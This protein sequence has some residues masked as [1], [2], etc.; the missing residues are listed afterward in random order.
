MSSIRRD[1]AHRLTLDDGHRLPVRSRIRLGGHRSRSSSRPRMRRRTCRSWSRRSSEAFRPLVGRVDRSASARRV[2]GRGRRRRLDRP[3]GPGPPPTGRDLSRAEA[4]LPGDERRPVGGDGRGVPGGAG[5]LGR[6]ARRG[7]SESS[8]RPGGALGRPAGLR[9]G[10]G[11]ADDARGSSG[12]SGS[13]SRL[14]NRVRNAVLGQSIRDT[15]CSVRIFPREVAL[16]L[17][18]FRGVHRFFGPLL[19]RE[20]CRIVQV[21]VGAPAEDPWEVALPLRQPVDPGGRRPARRRLAAPA[22][23]PVRGRLAARASAGRSSQARI[24]RGPGGVPMTGPDCLAG[25]SGSSARGSSRP[26][27]WSSGSPRRRSGTRWS[28]SPSGG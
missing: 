28:R 8:G 15:G 20:G 11:L 14:A 10:P 16:R 17:P 5:G 18:M 24:G 27:S 3:D 19:L 21:P 9:R 7:P 1:H 22:A 25:R 26:G 23:D 6:R 12:R 2:R 13:I 4:G